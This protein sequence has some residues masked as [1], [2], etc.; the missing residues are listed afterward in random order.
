MIKMKK[1]YGLISQTTFDEIIRRFKNDCQIVDTISDKLIIN[2]VSIRDDRLVFKDINFRN[3]KFDIDL[4]NVQFSH[5]RFDDCTFEL[6]ICASVINVCVFSFCKFLKFELLY[7]CSVE[8][9]CFEACDFDYNTN[10][11]TTKYSSTVHGIRFIRCKGTVEFDD[12]EKLTAVESY[13]TFAFYK[14]ND[15]NIEL[16]SVSFK[17]V[18]GIKNATFLQSDI[19]FSFAMK[20]KDSSYC[21][22]KWLSLPVFENIFANCCDIDY[23][24]TF[25]IILVKNRQNIMSIKTLNCEYP[26]DNK[27]S[28][29]INNIIYTGYIGSRKSRT[30]YDAKNDLVHCGCWKND[31]GTKW[32]GGDDSGGSV[33]EFEKE[34]LSTYPEKT[35]EYH[36]QYMAEIAKF[37]E[38]KKEYKELLEKYNKHVD[39]Y[40]DEKESDTEENVKNV[41]TK[42]CK[43]KS[44]HDE[45]LE[46]TRG[47][48]NSQCTIVYDKSQIEVPND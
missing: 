1:Q 14:A 11:F 10:S 38:Y 30:Y 43:K 42:F 15:I 2:K 29:L 47:F 7:D 3:I 44:L 32:N 40:Y 8:T 9:V 5:C 16:S 18:K 17:L 33:D 48:L 25:A 23:N 46:N 45:E 21:S 34:V 28:M 26:M 13:M 6:D 24:Y 12:V 41:N 35:N 22:N 37:R 20:D 27:P 4:N 31:Y 19:S 39:A 36:K